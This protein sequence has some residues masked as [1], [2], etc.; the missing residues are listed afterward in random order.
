MG[1]QLAAAA[2]VPSLPRAGATALL[3]PASRLGSTCNWAGTLGR[4]RRNKARRIRVLL[5]VTRDPSLI[6]HTQVFFPTNVTLV[7]HARSTMPMPDLPGREILLVIVIG[8]SL[9]RSSCVALGRCV[10]FGRPKM[11]VWGHDRAATERA[12]QSCML[13]RG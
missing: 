12:C 7:T 4:Q 6:S 11:S 1:P 2:A 8:I 5:A 13:S 10:A 3:L 9:T